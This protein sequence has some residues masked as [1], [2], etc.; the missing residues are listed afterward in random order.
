MTAPPQTAQPGEGRQIALRDG[1]HHSEP[2]AE[3]TLTRAVVV[4]GSI[5]G[6]FAAAAAAPHFDEVWLLSDAS[7][8]CSRHDGKVDQFCIIRGAWPC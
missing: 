6:M 5:A 7:C 2:L 4:G 1:A 3:R 8:V